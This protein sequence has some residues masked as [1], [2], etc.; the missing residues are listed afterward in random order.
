MFPEQA[1][2][3]TRNV[4]ARSAREHLFLIM[5]WRSARSSDTSFP[6]RMAAP[7]FAFL[8]AHLTTSLS[9]REQDFGIHQESPWRLA[10]RGSK[11]RLNRSRR[12][13]PGGSHS[14]SREAVTPDRKPN[15]F[16]TSRSMTTKTRRLTR[17]LREKYRFC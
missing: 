1:L 12:F 11:F 2:F 15:H 14:M 17:S 16:Q 8:F 7:R 9:T 5:A 4:S 3:C 13:L 10:V 6:I